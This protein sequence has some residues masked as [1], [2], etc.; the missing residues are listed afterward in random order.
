MS[1]VPI[2]ATVPPT[3]DQDA[4]TAAIAS[5][6]KSLPFLINLSK[7]DRKAVAKP[8]AK[9][10]TF[11]KEAL[12]VAIQNPMMLPAS[13]NAPEMQNGVQLF[14]YLASLQLPL[15]QILQEV[16]D[17]LKQV[18]TQ[19]YTAARLIYASASSQFAGP[20]LQLAA[21]Q[22]GKH[23]GRK[24]KT[25]PAANGNNAD[26]A[27]PTPV[28]PVPASPAPATVPP[29]TLTSAATPKA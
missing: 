21:D 13:F 16:D 8:S 5:L 24:A 15:R 19:T 29:A 6:K 7:A 28:S 20:P 12:N 4:V 14:Q 25:K 23:F 26:N 9:A 27:S 3:T 11:I 22:L 2:N 18:G 17:T 10:Q 1:T